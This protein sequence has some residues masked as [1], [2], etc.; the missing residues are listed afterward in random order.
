MGRDFADFMDQIRGEP[1]EKRMDE[2]SEI[3]T[4]V[5]SIVVSAIDDLSNR[6]AA[7]EGSLTESISTLTMVSQ[8]VATLTGQMSQL[9]AGGVAPAPAMPG[10]PTITPAPQAP[11]M[12]LTAPPP[13]P[14]LQPPAPKPRPMTGMSAR[15]AINSELK[16]LFGKRRT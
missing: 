7:L 10:Q 8:S 1:V 11:G 3:L 6:M 14:A 12:V 15:S 4:R 13:S 5:M 2:I 16:A 9:R